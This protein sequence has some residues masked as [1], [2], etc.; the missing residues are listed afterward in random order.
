MLFFDL[1]FDLKTENHNNKKRTEEISCLEIK[2]LEEISSDSS[3]KNK[4]KNQHLFHRHHLLLPNK[5]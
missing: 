4:M 2:V 3:P 1:V 5:G